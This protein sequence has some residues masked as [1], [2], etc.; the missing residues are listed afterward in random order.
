MAGT[1]QGRQDPPLRPV[2]RNRM[3]RV[4]VR[5]RRRASSALP[6]PVTIQNSYSL[7][8]RGIDNELAEALLPQRM[9]LLA[10]SPLATGMLT[11][12]YRRRRAAAERA[13]HAV[14]R[15]GT[16]LSQADRA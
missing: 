11:G 5:A 2:E 6:P 15:I 4:R 1:D 7:V 14:R 3:G 10:Y 12:K 16:S 9:S 8:S 13:L